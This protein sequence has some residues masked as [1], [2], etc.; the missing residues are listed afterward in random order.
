MN[1]RDSSLEDIYNMYNAYKFPTFVIGIINLYL[2]SIGILLHPYYYYYYVN[3]Y[4][5]LMTDSKIYT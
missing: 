1:N 4:H 2:L 3:V 5:N